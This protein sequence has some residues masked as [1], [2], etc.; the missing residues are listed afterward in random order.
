MKR[1]LV[2]EARGTTRTV[3]VET[4]SN[5]AERL[6]VTVD[7]QPIAVDARRVRAGTWSIIIEHRAYLV[8][9]EARRGG[10]VSFTIGPSSGTL[11]LE[12]ARARRLASAV[13]REQKVVRGETISAPIAGRIVKLHVA[14][15]EVVAPGAA[16]VVLEAMKMENELAAVRGGTVAKIL[17]Q[18]GDAVDTNEKLVELA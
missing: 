10:Q 7:G 2:S 8:E 5:G 4:S 1:E 18:V 3:V 16:V 6:S 17:R 11:A 9:L 12:D 15:G 14:V 13:K